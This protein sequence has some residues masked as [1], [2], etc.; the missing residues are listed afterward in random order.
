[1]N[2]GIF[3][4]PVS[5]SALPPASLRVLRD[6]L[7]YGV[8][9]LVGT[10]SLTAWFNANYA[11]ALNETESLPEK[12]FLIEKGA[13]LEVGGL[14]AFRV[15][16]GAKHYPMD[17][18]FVKQV[19]AGPGDAIVRSSGTIE[20]NGHVLPTKETSSRGEPL[21]PLDLDHVPDGAWF[22]CTHHPDSYD[23]RY[24]DI[25]VIDNARIVGRA[26]ALF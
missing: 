4:M 7:V 5:S 2:T 17:T 19:C 1:M 9:S 21:A 26:R 23:S 13:P 10:A 16:A 24:A 14:M 20:I 22:A 12:V 6:G 8:V 18:V 25:A 3:S 11:L 15:G